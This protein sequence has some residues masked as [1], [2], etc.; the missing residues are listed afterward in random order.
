MTDYRD[1]KLRSGA[2]KY[3]YWSASRIEDIVVENGIRPVPA[4]VTTMST[5][6]LVPCAR[7]EY[8]PRRLDRNEIATRIEMAIGHDAAWDFT[9]PPPVRFAHGR[10]TVVF[11]EFA[12][13]V[14][15][16]AMGMVFTEVTGGDGDRVAI[17]LFGSIADYADVIT[18]VTPPV[19]GWSAIRISPRWNG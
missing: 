11:S 2:R 12:Y 18:D 13:G 8:E 19:R 3:L 14:E 6:S 16:P 1:M 15:N 17:C 10:G 5:P 9:V 7:P 4:S